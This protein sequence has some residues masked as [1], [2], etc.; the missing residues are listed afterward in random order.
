MLDWM[1]VADSLAF[2][3]ITIEIAMAIVLVASMAVFMFVLTSLLIRALL[4][5]EPK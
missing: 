5:W 2:T 3:D 1:M 4:G